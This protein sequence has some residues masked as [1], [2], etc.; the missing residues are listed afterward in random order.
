MFNKTSEESLKIIV[1]ELK[2]AVRLR[3]GHC[4]ED[5]YS[6]LASLL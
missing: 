6:Q 2:E 1:E 4:K 3:T 5:E